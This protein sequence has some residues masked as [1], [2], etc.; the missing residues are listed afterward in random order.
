[1]WSSDIRFARRHENH[2]PVPRDSHVTRA[3][4]IRCRVYLNLA[5]LPLETIPTTHFWHHDFNASVATYTGRYPLFLSFE[6]YCLLTQRS[7]SL[8]MVTP[9]SSLRSKPGYWTHIDK[10][11]TVWSLHQPPPHATFRRS[12][13]SSSKRMAG[14]RSFEM[15]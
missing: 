4:V 3:F 14:K 9:N 5:V 7:T 12:L 10:H 15:R 8:Y 1:M 2:L 11:Y 13:S 6:T